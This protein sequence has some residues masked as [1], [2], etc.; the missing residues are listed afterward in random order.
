MMLLSF[1]FEDSRTTNQFL[2]MIE[3]LGEGFVGVTF[4]IKPSCSVAVS[5]KT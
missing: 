1:I 3:K 5:L 4:R 2:N